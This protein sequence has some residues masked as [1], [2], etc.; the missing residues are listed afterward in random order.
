MDQELLNS[1][2]ID[3]WEYDNKYEELFRLKLTAKHAMVL[4]KWLCNGEWGV[5]MRRWSY[6]EDR[7]LGSGIT[8]NEATWRDIHK[9]IASLHNMKRFTD[10]SNTAN[11]KYETEIKIDKTYTLRTGVFRADGIPNP[12]FFINM[13]HNQKTMFKGR[14][15]IVG[16]MLRFDTITL[17]LKQ[18]QENKLI[19]SQKQTDNLDRGIDT[20][21]GRRIY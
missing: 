4:G 16:I 10:F 13:L 21:S 2:R 3:E 19:D 17:F 14:N 11:G 15:T 5:D 18:C 20:R 8:L 12:Y 7:L 9:Y 1:I 6:N